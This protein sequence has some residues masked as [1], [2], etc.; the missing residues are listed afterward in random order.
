[1]ISRTPWLRIWQ[2]LQLIAL[3]IGSIALASPVWA[4]AGGPFEPPG[5]NPTQRD[6]ASALF[7]ACTTGPTLTNGLQTRCDSI[8]A[9]TDVNAQLNAVDEVSPEQVGAAGT[10]ATR[11]SGGQLSQINSTLSSRMASVLGGA[12]AGVQ[13]QFNG[14]WADLLSQRSGAA[15]SDDTAMGSRLGAFLS[16]NYQFGEVDTTFEAVGFDF[17]LGGVTAG[18]DYRVTD[19]VVL[20]GAFSY[21]RSE[22]SFDDSAGD[23]EANSYNGSIFGLFNP[24]PELYL[25]GIVTIGGVDYDLTRRIQ[26][27][28]TGD[29]VNARTN[30]DTTGVQFSFAG[31]IGY[32][33]RAKAFTASPYFGVE[34]RR[35]NLDAYDESGGAGWAAAVDDQE[36]NSLTSQIGARMSYAISTEMGVLLPQVRGEW[37][38]EYSD[39][40]RDIGAHF[41]NDPAR[42]RFNI[43]TEDPDRNYGTVGADLS[44]TFAGG[45]SA[46][47]AYEALVGYEDVSSHEFTL[48]GRVEF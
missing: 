1:V 48:G 12:V 29:A 3:S 47:A 26:Y 5:V 9:E 35:L 8:A 19:S 40:G 4:Q 30:A 32:D 16:G 31:E 36:I 10:E 18:L 11:V 37:V 45:F 39:D 20:G 17:D 42:N 6:M 15:G 22:A 41:V 27:T 33:Y 13:T 7:T 24:T 34:S 43:K 2:T 25:S 28:V 14:E 44:M 46:F 23:S 38:H 21:M